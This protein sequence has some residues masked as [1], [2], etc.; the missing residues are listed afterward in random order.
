LIASSSDA[1]PETKAWY[2]GT[3][4]PRVL[5]LMYHLYRQYFPLIDLTTYKKVMEEKG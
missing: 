5:Y 4:F 3:G 2:S 1:A